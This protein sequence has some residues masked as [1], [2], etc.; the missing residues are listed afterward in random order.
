MCY[1]DWVNRLLGLHVPQ[2]ESA[3]ILRRAQA[4][5]YVQ[6]LPPILVSAMLSAITIA[7]VAIY[8]GWLIFPAIWAACVIST[9]Y[10]GIVRIR[11]VRSRQR[12]DAPSAR[13]VARIIFNSA[14]VALPWALLPIVL[15][16]GLRRSW[17]SSSPR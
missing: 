7:L 11:R 1:D 17:R 14:V 5:R 6:V 16:P 2:A 4:A 8:Y 12:T 3:A 15:T 9:A 13:F 10:V